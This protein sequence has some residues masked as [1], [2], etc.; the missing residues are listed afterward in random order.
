VGPVIHTFMTSIIRY[1][2][3]EGVFHECRTIPTMASPY[4]RRRFELEDLVYKMYSTLRLS[5]YRVVY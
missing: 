5:Y 4:Y 1:L 3:G 2:G